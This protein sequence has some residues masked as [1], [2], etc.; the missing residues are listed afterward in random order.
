MECDH[1]CKENQGM[2]ENTQKSWAVR[3]DTTHLISAVEQKN[4]FL[5]QELPS[6]EKKVNIIMNCA[7]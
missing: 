2:L 5:Q 4:D 7:V 3:K 1:A 6:T